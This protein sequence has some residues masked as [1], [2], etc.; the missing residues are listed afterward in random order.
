MNV[1]PIDIFV[2]TGESSGDLH[3]AHLINEIKRYSHDVSVTAIGG[4]KLKQSGAEIL[5]D[6]S[7][8]NFVGFVK[9]FSN[10]NYLRKK[11]NT[12]KRFIIDNNPKIIVLCD[13]PG[14]NLRLAKSIRKIYNGKII[15]YITPQVWA[16]NS[17]RIKTIRQCIDLCLVVFPFEK[18]LF[19]RNKINNEYIVHPLISQI[20][21]FLLSYTPSVKNNFSVSLMPGSRP[22]E[23]AKMLPVMNNISKILTGKYGFTVKL[24]CSDNNNTEL[25][26]KYYTDPEGELV[27]PGKDSNLSA[28]AESDFVVTKFGTSNLECGILCIPFCAVY[29]AGF[30]NYFIARI[31][32]KIKYVS[33]VNIIF[34]KEVIK[35]FIQ[36][37]FTV[38]NVI[39]EI[40]KVKND[41]K[42]RQRML[43]DF[44]NIRNYFDIH[45]ENA[46]LLIINELK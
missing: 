27:L 9:V 36:N 31:L 45:K 20:N 3:S 35:E 1:T 17:S 30:I 11:L 19:N 23:I 32:I 42:Y 5:F 6:Y 4:Y 41:S 15:Y 7:E 29:K 13:F 16:W 24:I 25:Y 2:V 33:L 38:D 12:V 8:I 34:N 18:E 39:N 28:I 10:L 40:L 44:R 21:E 46:A 14:F 26:K 43:N 37:D 22:D